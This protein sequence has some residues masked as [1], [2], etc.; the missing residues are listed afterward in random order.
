L[1]AQFEKDKV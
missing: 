1:K